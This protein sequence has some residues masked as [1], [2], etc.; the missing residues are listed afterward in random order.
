MARR[1]AFA[2][3]AALIFVL[4][5]VFHAIIRFRMFYITFTHLILLY[6][7]LPRPNKERARSFRKSAARRCAGGI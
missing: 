5:F 1:L 6:L 7:G 2:A 3:A 4:G